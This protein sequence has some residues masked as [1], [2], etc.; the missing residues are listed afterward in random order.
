MAH[1]SLI[2]DV[3]QVQGETGVVGREDWWCDS[4]GWWNGNGLIQVLV[5]D[6]VVEL[7]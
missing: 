4:K 6:C 7:G 1:G 3:A 2:G 5:M